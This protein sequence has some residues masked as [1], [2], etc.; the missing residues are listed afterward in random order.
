[1]ACELCRQV[2]GQLLDYLPTRAALKI[3]K[4]GG[5]IGNNK[6][7]VPLEPGHNFE[8]AMIT[9]KRA[10]RYGPEDRVVP[11]YALPENNAEFAEGNFSAD[12]SMLQQPTGWWPVV[13]VVSPGECSMTTVYRTGGWIIVIC[14]YQLMW[15]Q[16]AAWSVQV[17]PVREAP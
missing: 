7:F 10:G 5:F 14:I 4:C 3:H 8:L 15:D 12:P 11:W 6:K 1:M 2:W 16:P 13:R 17:Y 9:Y